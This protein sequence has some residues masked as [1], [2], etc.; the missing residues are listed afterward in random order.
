MMTTSTSTFEEN[1]AYESQDGSVWVWCDK[2]AYCYTVFV[3]GLTHSASD[4]VYA[5]T[6]DGLSLAKAR[7]DHLAS[8]LDRPDARMLDRP[9]L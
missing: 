3:S 6:E 5:L 1:I 9:R 2:I 8:W 7:V 4:S